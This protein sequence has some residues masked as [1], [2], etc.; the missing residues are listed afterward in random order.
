MWHVFQKRVVVCVCCDDRVIVAFEIIAR[1]LGIQEYVD[2]VGCE[3][4]FTNFFEF[5]GVNE[6][7]FNAYCFF[8]EVGIYKI[9]IAMIVRKAA[10]VP[11]G[12]AVFRARMPALA[13]DRVVMFHGV[14]D[15][16][17]FILALEAALRI[18]SSRS[19]KSTAWPSRASSHAAVIPKIPPPTT[20]IFISPMKSYFPASS[21]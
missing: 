20:P 14:F 19:Y 1:C 8:Y 21:T 7:F 3:F 13:G 16:G 10:F 11:H 17:V 4:L 2:V 12:K 5:I 15:D 18:S 9:N 6:V